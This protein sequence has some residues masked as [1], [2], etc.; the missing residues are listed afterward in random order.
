MSERSFSVTPIG[1][2]RKDYSQ[3]I[4][5]AVEPEIRSHLYRYNWAVESAP[6]G[7]PD[8]LVT[9]PWPD[10]HRVQLYFM[11]RAGNLI[12]YVPSDVKYLIYNIFTSGNYNA[13]T[14][15]ALYKYTYPDD[16]YVETVTEVFGYGDAKVPIARGHECEPGVAYWVSLHQWSEK[17]EFQGSFTI[18]SMTDV[19]VG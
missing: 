16:V 15:A 5:M 2:G 4:E 17:E 12:G 18:H 9:Y 1:V 11:D 7:D 8:A 14:I 19:I 6:V 10:L 3:S 13:L